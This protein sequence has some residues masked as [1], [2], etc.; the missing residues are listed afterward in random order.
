MK[1]VGMTRAKPASAWVQREMSSRTTL[2]QA[3][4]EIWLWDSKMKCSCEVRNALDWQRRQEQ[5]CPNG[6]VAVGT[7][8]GEVAGISSAWLWLTDT[9]L[10][11][12][13]EVGGQV[14]LRHSAGGSDVHGAHL[15][16][17][18]LLRMNFFF[19]FVIFFL[20]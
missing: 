15:F 16:A 9:G 2:T 11:T 7:F 4:V 20:S 6:Q 5:K 13:I 3:S 1:I 12:S 10:I 17:S 18:L 19:K 14:S 8:V